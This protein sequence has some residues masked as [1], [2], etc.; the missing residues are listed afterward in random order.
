MRWVQPPE[1]RSAETTAAPGLGGCVVFV[2]SHLLILNKPHGLL[3]VPGK[4]PEN[5]DCL[6][7]RAQ[8]IWPDALVVHRLDMATSGLMAMARGADAQRFLSDAFAH[9]VTHKRYEAVVTGDIDPNAHPADAEGWHTIDLPLV[10]DWPNRPRS[11]VCHE[12]GKASL[13]RWRVI[14]RGVLGHHTRLAL[15]PVTGRSHQLRVHLQALG[16]PILGDR[17]YACETSEQA[18]PRMLLHATQLG[19]PHPATSQH[20]QW[21][22]KAPF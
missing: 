5:A 10:L 11:M 19:L 17:L 8:A 15:E 3:S 13:T 18:V 20:M 9:R 16:Y 21:H 22:S 2:D 6:S 4:G 14:E 12:R 7:A 1:W